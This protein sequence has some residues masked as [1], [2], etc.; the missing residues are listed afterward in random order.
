MTY[1][2]FPGKYANRSRAAAIGRLQ[3]RAS[4]F[5]HS[6]ECLFR[7]RLTISEGVPGRARS[8]RMRATYL[9][10]ISGTFQ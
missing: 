8:S 4:R 2:W 1:C 9:C 6:A 7:I 5:P 3:P 10:E